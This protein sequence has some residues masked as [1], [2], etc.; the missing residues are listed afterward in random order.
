M[1]NTFNLVWRGLTSITGGLLAGILTAVGHHLYYASLEG[2]YTGGD[3]VIL[4]YRV[5]HQTFAISIGTGFAFIARA[6]LL[7]AVSGAYAQVFW[8]AATHARKLNTLEEVDA[9]FSVLSNLFAFSQGRVWWKYP[10][11]L[12]IAL[13]AWLLPIAFTIPSSSLAVIFT[14][15]TTSASKIVPNF[16]FASL[17]Y[18]SDMS[19]AGFALNNEQ[20]GVTVPSP[21]YSYN[22]PSYEVERIATAVASG[23]GILP[24][25]PPA[26]NSSW[27]LNFY[28]PSIRCHP[29]D[30]HTR[31]DM[32]TNIAHWIWNETSED[33][34]YP[35]ENCL[36]PPG[37]LAWWSQDGSVVPFTGPISPLTSDLIDYSFFVA[38]MPDLVKAGDACDRINLSTHSQPLG[39]GNMT[40]LQCAL[41]NSSYFVTFSYQSGS[42]SINIQADDRELLSYMA[43][44]DA[45]RQI[46]EGSV[47]RGRDKGFS[48][49]TSIISTVLAETPELS[50]LSLKD[51]GSHLDTLQTELLRRNT[52]RVQSLFSTR[53]MHQGKPL[54]HAIEEMFQN[55][56]IS[57]LSSELLQPNATSEFAPPM[58]N[59]TI[60]SYEPKYHYSSQQLWIAY[61]VAIAFSAATSIF[62]VRAIFFGNASYSNDFSAVYRTAY[63][64]NLDVVM[65]AEDMKATDPLPRYIAKATLY[66]TSTNS[67]NQ[68]A[69]RDA[70]S[71]TMATGESSETLI[72]RGI[73]TAE[74]GC[75]E[76]Q[77]AE[78]SDA[79]S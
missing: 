57:L 43:I 24:I 33:Y 59:V 49:D 23:G 77:V 22:G 56:T 74:A 79:R 41:H 75:N 42:Q 30:A 38:V 45:F 47:K 3:L 36:Q 78:Y 14:P 48:V 5:S 40:Y 66:I 13:I 25:T 12:L 58:P 35:L 51:S 64:S 53:N 32:E 68:L 44:A 8:R 62:G 27:Q 76:S 52:S 9:M 69:P 46:I 6:F 63:G 37:Y 4:G 17:R 39:P 71:F 34:G 31:L 21:V 11:L 1:A 54:Q 16:D 28:G 2:T 72:E 65:R 60:T 29:V 15:V 61:G 10:A 18:V 73:E 20:N 70:Q 26:P 67:T 55:I 19:V 50:F 7:F